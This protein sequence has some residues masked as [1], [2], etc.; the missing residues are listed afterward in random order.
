M[1]T[2]KKIKIKFITAVDL[3]LQMEIAKHQDRLREY[4]KRVI[5]TPRLLI[6]DEVGYVP[7]SEDNGNHFFDVI[8]KRYE[9]GSVVVTSNLPFSQW[10]KI[11]AGNKALTAATLDRLL[12]H[13]HIINI[14][15]NSYRLKEKYKSGLVK[16]T[17]N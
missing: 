5:L 2:Q 4:I 13:S 10:E 16:K 1:A 9:K 8:S 3:L 7:F 12:H 11:F 14:T 6:I 15:G 17:E